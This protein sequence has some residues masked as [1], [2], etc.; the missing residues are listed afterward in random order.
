VRV[1]LVGVFLFVLVV[2]FVGGWGWR[3]GGGVLLVS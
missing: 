1:C 2:V 3:V